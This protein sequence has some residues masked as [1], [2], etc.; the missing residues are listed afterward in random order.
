MTLVLISFLFFFFTQHVITRIS[1][2][3]PLYCIVI[4]QINKLPEDGLKSSP[5]TSRYIENTW[6]SRKKYLNVNSPKKRILDVL[7]CPWV[8]SVFLYYFHLI[9]SMFLIV[10]QP[11]FFFKK[12]NNGRTNTMCEIC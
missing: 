6:I 1:S 8:E 3:V 11:E 2:R 4:D 5:K 7:F 12:V 9:F 10:T